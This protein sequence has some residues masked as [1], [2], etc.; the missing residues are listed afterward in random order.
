MTCMSGRSHPVRTCF[1]AHVVVDRAVFR[2]PHGPAADA[3]TVSLPSISMWRTPPLP[4]SEPEE[5]AETTRW[6][7]T[8]SDA[9]GGYRSV[10]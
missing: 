6:I 2:E 8:A 4:A 9:P 5:H 3:L 10:T 1:L 7:S